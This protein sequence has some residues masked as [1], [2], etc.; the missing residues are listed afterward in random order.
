MYIWIGLVSDGIKLVS[1][2]I[3]LMSDG[4]G[5]VTRVCS[6]AEV[7]GDIAKAFGFS[8]FGGSES[9]ID[10]HAITDENLKRFEMAIDCSEHEGSGAIGSGSEWRKTERQ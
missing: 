3:E 7:V 6:S 4:V 5:K 1:D 10:G 2:V 9:I 8:E